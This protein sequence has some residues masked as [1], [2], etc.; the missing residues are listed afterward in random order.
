[1]RLSHRTMLAT[2]LVAFSALVVLATS[3]SSAITQTNGTFA[4]DLPLSKPTTLGPANG[5]ALVY[6][7]NALKF[8]WKAVPGATTYDVQ[9][10]QQSS[11][12]INCDTKEAWQPENI[13]FT[14]NTSE[15]GWVPEQTD[16]SL[17]KKVWTGTYCWRIRPAG[18]VPGTWSASPRF[19]ISWPA[20]PTNLKFYSDENGE[21]P[22][23]GAADAQGFD[24]GY[25]EWSAVDGAPRYEVQISESPTFSTASIF[26]SKTYAGTRL[27]LPA[28]PD[29]NY[30]WRVRPIA[31]NG[32]VGN[33]SSSATFTIQR[34]TRYW[35]GTAGATYPAQGATV[36][37]LRFGYEPV[38]GASYYRYMVSK[39]P[40]SFT[41]LD[42]NGPYGAVINPDTCA[43]GNSRL[44][45]IEEDD[46]STINN[47]VSMAAMLDP[48]VV[49]NLYTWCEY[50][51]DGAGPG[52]ATTQV[53]PDIPDTIYWRVY[54]VW[55]LSP[56]TETG[57]NV[58]TRKIVGSSITRSFELE[59]YD[60]TLISNPAYAP[61][62]GGQC[63]DAPG[64]APDEDCLR[65][66]GG[67]MSPL[68][69]T[70]HSST[71][72]V[73]FFEWGAYPGLYPGNLLIGDGPGSFRVQIARDTEFNNQVIPTAANNLIRGWMSTIGPAKRDERAASS[74]G[75]FR[76]GSI[77]RS[78][79]LTTGLPDEGQDGNGYFWRSIPCQSGPG[80]AD[81][82]PFLC[83]PDFYSDE[84]EDIWSPGMK[85]GTPD[86]GAL[87]FRKRVEVSTQVIQGFTDTTPLL[88]VGP[89][90]ASTFSDWQRGIQGADHYVFELSR[91]SSFDTS[92]QFKTTV[93]RI[94]PWG[95]TPAD[96][97]EPGTWHWR[98]RAVDRDG[99]AGTWSNASTFSIAAAAPTPS[100]DSATIGVGGTVEWNRVPGA[101]EYEVAWSTDGSFNSGV[102]TASTLQT[103]YFLPSS[104]PGAYSWR[105]RAKTGPNA[106]GP[107]STPKDI[108]ILAKTAISYGMSASVV[109]V[110]SI[111]IVEGQLV[112]AGTPRN[113]QVVELQR[114]NVSC[115]ASGTYSKLMSGTSGKNLDDG[116]VRYRFKPTRS[117][118]YRLAWNFATG[119]VYSA[120]FEIGARPVVSFAPQ[121]RSVK[122]GQA[123]CSKIVSKQAITGT[124]RVQYK[125]G[126]V[127]VTAKSQRVSAMKRRTQCAA[128]GR[129][130]VFPVRLVIDNIVHPTA[131]WKLFETT[132]IGG[133]LVKTADSFVIVR[134][135]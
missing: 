113:S 23:S 135:R 30:T 73:P 40:S 54:P 32:I 130:G 122:R 6:P 77:N 96:P 3:A 98:V 61:V 2:V 94:V 109:N 27:L 128:I 82:G 91:S 114:K 131:G 52:T 51:T 45:A 124:L 80:S 74:V 89:K 105:V 22:R 121:K 19:S 35:T 58:P 50:D 24:T 107:W 104:A 99:L 119:T 85:F 28:M 12:S 86:S 117:G 7:V 108:T 9:V 29:N 126:K 63:K 1:M 37:D 76:F 39:S 25:L 59:P 17:G 106:Y 38:P 48:V 57:W 16:D 66:L 116:F 97:L 65:N 78:F 44:S 125:V 133:G 72:Q 93:P 70:I 36:N 56:T 115:A 43:Y 103:A 15:L 42:S 46:S 47:W 75:Q 95:A 120:A 8:T 13:L 5:S 79:V 67:S 87:E 112:V 100:S 34:D 118:C 49:K 69:P 127:W 18:A 14:H 64:L 88:R 10:A 21:I 26:A 83:S 41:E 129:G 81:S 68:N 123:F 84:T 71:M 20:T 101:I 11:T 111:V 62:A 55:Q 90:N 132:T 4:V 31:A 102:T 134:S 53:V 33:W 110:G 92:D 60:N